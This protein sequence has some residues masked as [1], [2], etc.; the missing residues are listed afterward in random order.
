MNHPSG[1][2]GE[3][4]HDHRKRTGFAVE[5]TDVMTGRRVG[6]LGDL[7]AGGLMLISPHAP[8]DEAIFQLRLSLPGP[9]NHERAIEV[10]VQALWH[11]RTAHAGKVWVGHRIIAIDADDA[12]ALNAWLALPA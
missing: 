4:R 7:S 5:V 8:P 2:H 3:Q 9:G 10:G 11:R 1:R 6:Q 12:K